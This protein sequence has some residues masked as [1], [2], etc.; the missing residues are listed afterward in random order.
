M[1]ESAV[2]DADLEKRGAREKGG[3]HS[4]NYLAHFNLQSVGFNFGPE[5]RGLRP[6]CQD[7]P[8]DLPLHRSPV[9]RLKSIIGIMCI[10]PVLCGLLENLI[11]T[12]CNDLL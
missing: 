10:N 8:P 11:L 1:V 3:G 9:L 2:A 7:T 4:K 6:P 12:H 5:I